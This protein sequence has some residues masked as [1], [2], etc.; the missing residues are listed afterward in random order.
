LSKSPISQICRDNAVYFASKWHIRLYIIKKKANLFSCLATKRN[1]R[2]CTEGEIARDV[3]RT[4]QRVEYFANQ[5]GRDSLANILKAVS[6][7]ANVVGYCQG[8]NYVAA[9]LLMQTSENLPV[10]NREALVFGLMCGFIFN[11]DMKDLWR[12]GVPQLKLR[13]FQFDRLLQ[14]CKPHLAA[15]FKQIGLSPDFF[16]SQWF[17]TLLS[18]NVP[19]DQV[20]DEMACS[21][22]I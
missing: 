15:H 16:A 5:Q 22:Y 6:V 17:L 10:V 13:I 9:I 2:F 18:Y 21:K 8:M 14:Q 3:T 20:S 19:S 7:Y 1:V 11:L 4:F 12:P